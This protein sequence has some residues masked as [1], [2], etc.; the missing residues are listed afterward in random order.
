MIVEP[1]LAFGEAHRS[2]RCDLHGEGAVFIGEEVAGADIVGGVAIGAIGLAG[3]VMHLEDTALEEAFCLGENLAGFGRM[4][5]DKAA[6]FVGGEQADA[7]VGGIGRGIVDGVF[8]LWGSGIF[9]L[10]RGS[11]ELAAKGGPWTSIR[12]EFDGEVG[13]F[14]VVDFPGEDGCIVRR[15]HTDDIAYGSIALDDLKVFFPL[16]FGKDVLPDIDRI[17]FDEDADKGDMGRD[18]GEVFAFGIS[19]EPSVEE[20]DGVEMRHMDLTR[21]AGVDAVDLVDEVDGLVCMAVGDMGLEQ[22]SGEAGYLRHGLFS[23]WGFG[24]LS[25]AV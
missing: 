14:A 11:Y 2:G 18:A 16:G 1:R 6:Q 19:I 8:S 22:V 21:V 9:S 4:G 20:G 3:I 24:I 5:F 7:G 10:V 23:L 15:P 17:L 25:V 12:I 13:F